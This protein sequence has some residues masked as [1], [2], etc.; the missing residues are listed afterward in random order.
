MSLQYAPAAAAKIARKIV[1]LALAR[2]WKVSVNDGEEWTVKLSDK[3]DVI[4]AALATTEADTLRFRDAGA[5]NIGVVSLIYE[6][7]EDVVSDCSDKPEIL[8]LVEE[9]LA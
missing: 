5:Q 9:A 4:L 2:G 7:G 3:R 1:K 6:N 8:A